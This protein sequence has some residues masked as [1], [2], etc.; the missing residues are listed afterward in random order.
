MKTT[1]LWLREL[2]TY[3]RV[4][5]AG[6]DEE[7]VLQAINRV[8]KAHEGKIRETLSSSLKKVNGKMHLDI[9]FLCDAELIQK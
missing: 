6:T 1:T 9:E 8:Y 2:H 4:R 3:E 5:Q 7:F